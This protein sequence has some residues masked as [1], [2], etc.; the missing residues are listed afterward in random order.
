MAFPI[1]AGQ[2]DPLT[3]AFIDQN[4][5]PMSPTPAPDSPPSWSN[6]NTGAATLTVAAEGL[7]ATYQTNASDATVNDTISL[8]LVEQN[9]SL[10]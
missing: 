1:V 6:S 2:K 10:A 7:S 3:I 4:G 9:G 8:A 5:N